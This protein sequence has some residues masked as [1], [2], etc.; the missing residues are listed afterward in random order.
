MHKI[1][2]LLFLQFLQ[3]FKVKLSDN[4]DIAMHCGQRNCW[5]DEESHKHESPDNT[6]SNVMGTLW[7]ML[8]NRRNAF[9]WTAGERSISGKLS[10]VKQ[11][12]FRLNGWLC[13][14]VGVNCQ[15][16]LVSRSSQHSKT[17]PVYNSACFIM[18]LSFNCI[19]EHSN[20]LYISTPHPE[21]TKQH[22]MLILVVSWHDIKVQW[23]RL[24]KS[25]WLVQYRHMPSNPFGNCPDFKPRV[26]DD[27][28]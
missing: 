11:L 16:T 28:W 25:R 15:F 17:F 13:S 20:T 4:G 18:E 1:E 22:K 14:S 12:N 6:L 7:S 2:S 27:Q 9:K 3:Q 23:F 19:H 10:S 5:Y 21:L 8:V 24:N 26:P